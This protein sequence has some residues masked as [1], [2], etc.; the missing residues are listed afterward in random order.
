M[1]VCKRSNTYHLRR[2]VPARYR[3]IEPRSTIWVSLRTDSKS[4]A[5]RKADDAWNQMIEAW[6]AKL[7]GL[8]EQALERYE[9]AKELADIRGFQ[10][11]DMNSITQLPL[12]KIVNRIEAAELPA[13]QGVLGKMDATA[14]LGA[15]EKPV[16]TIEECLELYWSLA[17]DKTLGK[18]ADQLRRWK[19]PRKKAV[20]NFISVAGNKPIDA[21]TRDDMLDFRQFWFEKIEVGDVTPNSANKDLIHLGEILKTVNTMKRL[22]LDLPLG[23]LSFKEGEKSVRPPFSDHWI[24]KKLLKN[25]SLQGLNAEARAILIGMINTG[26][27]P[28]EACALTGETIILDHEVPHISIEANGR[29]LKTPYA[30]RKIPLTGV[31]L[32]IFREHRSGFPRYRGKTGLSATVNKYLR[33]NGL[34]E[35]PKHSLYSLRHAFEDRMLAAGIDDRIRRDVF[36][37]SL[38][39]ERYGRGASLSHVA[40]LLEE[41]AL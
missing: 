40:T 34:L 39:R 11:M 20:R 24:K 8:S 5:Y 10:Y 19:N 27:R 25:R 29:Q 30:R 9:A 31:S 38:N 22:G 13:K 21:I 18:S 41:I 17:K 15:A 26:Y 16:L 1:S 32:E 7:A 14:L 36:G 3:E 4:V 23:E 28:S 2:R 35:T 6:E 12:E 33:E 37:H